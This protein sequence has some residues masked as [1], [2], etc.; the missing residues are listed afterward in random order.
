[1]ENAVRSVWHEGYNADNYLAFLQELNSKHPGAIEFRIAETPLFVSKAF[2]Q[3]MIDACESIVDVITNEAFEQITERAIPANYKVPNQNSFSH[4]I[5]FDFGVC[6]NDKGELEPQLIEMQGFPTLFT[7]QVWD[8]IVVRKHFDIPANYSTYFSGL[9]PETY[10]QLLKEII[11]GNEKQEEVILL[12]IFPHKQKTRID[13]YCTEDY[14][15]IP[16]VCITE[17]LQEGKQLFYLRN[18]IKKPVKR[19]YNRV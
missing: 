8:D 4:F 6:S 15:G 9:N 14:L 13:F 12:E 11:V 2:T 7:F 16:I 10:I 5:A 19:I 3:K 18:G 1:M 17:L